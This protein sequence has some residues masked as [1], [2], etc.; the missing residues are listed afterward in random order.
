MPI[1]SATASTSVNPT[2]FN[3]IGGTTLGKVSAAD[4]IL[5]KYNELS[6]KRDSAL[7]EASAYKA[8]FDRVSEDLAPPRPRARPDLTPAPLP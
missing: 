8:K 6:A 4:S 2:T 3:S 5:A 1:A 7:A